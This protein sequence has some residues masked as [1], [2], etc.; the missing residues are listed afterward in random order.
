MT[1]LKTKQKEV[2]SK[3]KIIQQANELKTGV[4]SSIDKAD[5]SIENFQDQIGSTL[6]SYASSFKK[7][8]PNTDNIFDKIT[9]DLDKIL[10][11]N[12]Q[13]GESMV[14]KITRESVKETS[15]SI[16]PIF[17][18]NVRKLFFASDSELSCGIGTKMSIDDLTISPKEF[19]L[20]DTLQTDPQSGL[21]KII[22]ENSASTDKV[23]MNKVFYENFNGSPY[24]FTALDETN[25]FGIKWDSGNQVYNLSGLTA[26]NI[27]VDSFIT[28]Y[29]ESI[30]FP[31]ISDILKNTLS[32][33]VPVGGVNTENSNY[34]LNLNK[35]MRV[36]N[37]ICA[38]CPAPSNETLKQ[39]A[40]D[41]FNE[42]DVEIGAFFDFDDVE[43]IDIDDENLRYNKVLRFVDCNN[44]NLPVNQNIV[45]EFAYFSSTKNDITKEYNDAMSKIAKDA[46][47]NSLSIP[48]PQFLANL[49]FQTMK[50]L[51]KALLSSIFS[52]KMFFPIVVLWKMLK[53]AVSSAFISIKTLI[54][55]LGKFVF[56][57]LKDIFNKFL[58]VFWIKVKPQLALILKG[59]VTRLLKKSKKRYLVII[60]G[61]IDILTALLPFVGIKSCEDFYSAI[62]ALLNTLKVGVSQAI[63]GLLLQLSKRLPGYNE[64]RAI[65][66]AAEFLEANNIPTGDIFG[67]ENNIVQFVS[68]V[69]KG[70]QQE[71]DQNSFV[72]VSLDAATIPV[73]P[74]GGAA[75]ILPGLLKAHGKLT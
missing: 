7:K 67:Q 73:A 44:Y 3:F 21:G 2:T 70:H 19:D 64:D 10:P 48:F 22:Y 4:L 72:Q 53:S 62:L 63:P 52:P 18:S 61:L 57:L 36:I 54:K 65:M 51:P 40:V 58:T 12:S 50:N 39:N 8:I 16:K 34:D 74:L 75:V 23:K 9:R 66:N 41:Q 5:G 29:Y 71:M 20:L 37:K 49:D 55:N 11:K 35:L 69:I 28:K 30:E 38:A 68:S 56:N 46:A 27:T 47:N 1:D 60:R 17:L 59:L 31:K 25:L 42:G 14:R 26:N 15:E 33:V 6:T 45:E 43:G 32:L 13:N 24:N